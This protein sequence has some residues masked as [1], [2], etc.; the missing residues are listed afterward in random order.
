MSWSV[1]SKMNGPQLEHELLPDTQVSDLISC[2]SSLF[3]LLWCLIA[4]YLRHADPVSS[5]HALFVLLEVQMYYFL[6]MP[7]QKPLS[8]TT[9]N[10]LADSGNLSRSIEAGIL[11]CYSTA[12]TVIT[13]A[14]D[15]DATTNLLHY[16]P[17]YTIRPIAHAIIVIFRVIRS[18]LPLRHREI[19]VPEEAAKVSAHTVTIP[20]RISVVEGDLAWRLAQCVKLWD[21]T[22]APYLVAAAAAVAA[23][24]PSNTT[25]GLHDENNSNSN[26]A[27]STGTDP[28]YEP[29]LVET[30][31]QRML[32]ALGFDF[33]MR[34]KKKHGPVYMGQ[35]GPQP[36]AQNL[37]V[38]IDAG[39]A[40]GHTGHQHQVPS[41]SS[42]ETGVS[43]NSGG[44]PMGF[45]AA[46]QDQQQQQQTGMQANIDGTTMPP[47][48]TGLL[49]PCIGMVDSDA[50]LGTDWSFFDD[51]GWGFEMQ[52]S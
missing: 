51:F 9:G 33:M 20:R 21:V 52:A 46:Q 29:V 6:S 27:A 39:E 43:I 47:G 38:Q 1:C 23:A 4:D 15:L 7:T 32:A 36:Q 45:Q 22:S 40:G 50:L 14:V 16:L 34:W 10:S 24:S 44:G 28:D 31:R 30:F 19:I 41:S 3:F 13:R 25:M 11:R 37:G 18:D 49:F 26:Q 17:H 35:Y 2:I 5:L 48:E 42:N 8:L 12:S